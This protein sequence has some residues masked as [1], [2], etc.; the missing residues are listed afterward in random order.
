MREGAKVAHTFNG[1]VSFSVYGQNTARLPT[2][3][4]FDFSAKRNA[5]APL[6]VFPLS[7]D[8][9][10]AKLVYP[11]RLSSSLHVV[12]IALPLEMSGSWVLK[13]AGAA[14]LAVKSVNADRALLP[15][16]QLQYSWADS[17]CSAQQGLAAMGKLL[18]GVSRIDA[19]IG[20]GCSSA[21]EVTGHLLGGQG[22]PQI[23][24]GCTSPTLS[25]NYE[26]VCICLLSFSFN[27]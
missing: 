13:G 14:P 1:P 23:S 18:G 27:M 20:P 16:H 6:P 5:L 26:L 3:L 7:L 17:G 19:V 22:I 9:Q 11:A 21:C 15:G 10:A 2:T 8:Y 12:H 24:W 25:D 4:Q